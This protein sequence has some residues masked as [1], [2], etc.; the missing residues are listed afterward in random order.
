MTRFFTSR[1]FTTNGSQW[2]AGRIKYFQLSKDPDGIQ[3]LLGPET[4]MKSLM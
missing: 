1:K 2:M 4:L 3:E